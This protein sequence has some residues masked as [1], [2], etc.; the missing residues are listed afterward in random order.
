MNLLQLTQQLCLEIGLSAPASVV[1]STDSQI[2]QIFAIANRVG[3]ELAEEFEW[4]ELVKEN[5]ITTVVTSTT[6]TTTQGS[7]VITGIPSTTG[8]STRY[9]VTGVG[10]T[11]F[12]QIVS[13]DSSTQ[14]TL[15]MPATAS[16]TVNLTFA[17]TLYPLPS[18]WQQ[19][20]PQTEWDRTNRWPLN[21][22]KSSQE[23]Q[24]FK[25]GIVYAGPRLRF[26][27]RS[28]SIELNPVPTANGTLA[29]E[30]LSNAWV[31]PVSGSNKSTFTLDTDS[32]IF[33]DS[34]FVAALKLRFL[35]TKGLDYSYAMQDY[36]DILTKAKA[37]NKSAPK[38]FL[39]QS[40][41][42]VL[43]TNQNIQDGSYPAG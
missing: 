36:Q 9:G 4:E 16:G 6:G 2:Q 23:W 5:I 41:S 34:L 39:S 30:Y 18:D 15:N 26:R 31:V 24:N 40:Y 25:S 3:R 32:P 14:V 22:P 38:L 35:Q 20:I 12:S 10:I 21:G 13:V 42:S 27:I 11:P 43:L 19:E 29:L 17:Q 7:A 1:S 28:N 8:F 37:Q 33:R